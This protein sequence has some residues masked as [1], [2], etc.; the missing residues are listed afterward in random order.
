[1]TAFEKS[2]IIAKSSGSY[3]LI[4]LTSGSEKIRANK[5]VFVYDK[6]FFGYENDGSIHV[7][8]ANSA[9]FVVVNS[10]SNIFVKNS[11]LIIIDENSGLNIYTSDGKQAESNDFT[12]EIQSIQSDKRLTTLTNDKTFYHI[13]ENK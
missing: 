8:D 4:D 10:G 9:Q 1:M 2:Y 5:K 11:Y 3:R 6:Y 13:P 7:Y 12:N